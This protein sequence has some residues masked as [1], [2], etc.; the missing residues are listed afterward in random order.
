MNVFVCGGGWYYASSVW[1]HMCACVEARGQHWESF[2]I[3]FHLNHG[4]KVCL[5][6]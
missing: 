4:G 2:P 3:T 6:F 1:E 5:L